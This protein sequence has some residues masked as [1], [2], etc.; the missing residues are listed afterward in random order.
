VDG[1]G[2]N[3]RFTNPTGI[4]VDSA[5]NLYVSD[6]GN[7][8]IRKITPDGNVST[9]ILVP[10]LNQSLSEPILQSLALGSANTLYLTQSGAVLKL[11]LGGR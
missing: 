4:V 11:D 6:S 5:G 2:A 10:S 1:A 9:V 8:A 3:A 7:R